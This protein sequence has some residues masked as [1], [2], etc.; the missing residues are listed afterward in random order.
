MLNQQFIDIKTN[1]MIVRTP[2]KF[3]EMLMLVLVSL[4]MLK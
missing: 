1:T 3:T 2:V 4:L